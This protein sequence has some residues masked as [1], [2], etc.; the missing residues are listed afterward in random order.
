MMEQIR[1]IIE[2]PE[3]ADLSL[4]R[5]VAD[6]YPYFA[7]PG[8]LALKYHAD[9]LDSGQ[10]DALKLHLALTTGDRQALFDL[11]GEDGAGFK[12]IYPPEA[13]QAQLTTESAIDTFFATYGMAD[14]A[15]NALL[16]RLIF[17]PTP[18]YSEILA[19]EEASQSEADAA[20]ED[21][22]MSKIDA[23][24]RDHSG[25][26]VNASQQLIS[27]EPAAGREASPPVA[28]PSPVQTQSVQPADDSL[29]SESLAKIFIKQGRYERAYEI[30][31]NLSL[32]YPKKSIY[33]ADQLRFLQ[34]LIKI[35]QAEKRRND[36]QNN[37]KD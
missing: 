5:E 13:P 33:F 19:R 23:F 9:E 24:I 7:L 32:N 22:L 17:N 36:I 16:E 4:L 37:N 8:I 35:R 11:V 25:D 3:S 14:S 1:Q 27:P 20:S 29:L 6:R 2:N 28:A 12:D 31:S 10:T 30:I 21:P 18:D 34:K 15:E 26:E